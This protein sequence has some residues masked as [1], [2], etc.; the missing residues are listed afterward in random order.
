MMS[1]QSTPLAQAMMTLGR[2]LITA[3]AEK[4]EAEEAAPEKAAAG[5]L[6]GQRVT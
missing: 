5:R 3:L 2:R 6:F 1:A 4:A